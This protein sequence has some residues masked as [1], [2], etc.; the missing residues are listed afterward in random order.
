MQV[1]LHAARHS[2]T[3][4][5][6]CPY[7]GQP[8]RRPSAPRVDAADDRLQFLFYDAQLVI[9][10]RLATALRTVGDE[11]TLAELAAATAPIHGPLATW[12]ERQ[13]DDGVRSI[14]TTLSTIVKVLLALYVVS[15]EPA[16]PQQ[17]RTVVTNVVVGR[18]DQ[19]PLYGRGPCFC[20]SG[21]RYKKCHGRAT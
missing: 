10:Q 18:L 3:A 20:D 13:P 19:L 11:S 6:S 1:A 14:K 15:E 9:L 5:G 17:L 2:V 8:S 21:K 16:S 12:I 4:A 7:C